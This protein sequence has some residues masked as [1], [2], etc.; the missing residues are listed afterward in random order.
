MN[1]SPVS[2][3]ATPSWREQL[4]ASAFFALSGLAIAP[5]FW[6]GNPCGHDMST[7]FWRVIMFNMNIEDGYPFLQWG[8]HFLRGYGYPIFPFYAPLF[9]WLIAALHAAGFDYNAALRMAAWLALFLC[10]WG[11]YN[12][13]RRY[14]NTSL[15][16]AVAGLAYMFAP[17]IIYDGVERGALPELIALGLLPWVLSRVDIAWERQ[18]PRE[19]IKATAAF[20]LLMLTHNIIPLIGF[21]LIGALWLGR[22]QRVRVTRWWHEAQTG[23]AIIL[24]TLLVSAFFWLPAYLE[25]DYTQQARGLDSP[26][27]D[28]PVWYQH[29]LPTDELVAWPSD[30]ADVRLAN[31]PQ[32]RTLGIAQ[33]IIAG[34][35]LL[36][37][38]WRKEKRGT[39]LIWLLITAGALY[40]SNAS[41]SWLWELLPLPTFVQLPTRLLGIASLGLAILVGRFADELQLLPARAAYPFTAVLALAVCVSGW[42]W[43]TRPYCAFPDNPDVLTLATAA[44]WEG[45]NFY[46]WGGANGAE[47]LPRWADALPD[48]NGL[49]PQYKAGGPVNRLLLTESSTLINWQHQANGDSYQL[50]LSEPLTATYQSFYMPGWVAQINGEEVPI[51]PSDTYGLITVPLPAGTVDLEI[52]FGATPLRQA[53]VLVSLVALGG[54][55]WFGRRSNQTETYPFDL[56]QQAPIFTAVVGLILLTRVAVA[57]TNNPIEMNRFQ[58]GQLTHVDIAHQIVFSN[59]MINLGVSGDLTAA[60]DETL[61]ITQYWTPVGGIGVQYDFDMRIADDAGRQWNLPTQKPVF[62]IDIPGVNGWREGDYVRDP[63]LLD[64]LPGTPPGRYWLETT[65]FRRDVTF[66]LTAENAPTAADP[67]WARLGQIEI[68]PPQTQPDLT[69]DKAD[70]QTIHQQTLT[71]QP[72]LLLYGASL[73]SFPPVKPYDEVIIELLWQGQATF[74]AP[75]TAVLELLDEMGQPIA[76]DIL[77]VGGRYPTDQWPADAVVRQQTAWPLPRELES[78]RYTLQLEGIE[79]GMVEVVAPDRQFTRPDID[80]TAEATFGFAQLDGY[81]LSEL[82]DEAPLTLTLLW[83]ALEPTDINYRVFVHLRDAAGQIVAQSDGEPAQWARPTRGWLTDEYIV[84][85]HSLTLPPDLA[86]GEYQINVGLYNPATMARLGESTLTTIQ[87][88]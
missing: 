62:H 68:L 59:Q 23:V 9:N 26:F 87:K 17:Y 80:Q 88:P 81:T 3:K 31:P 2:S 69:P 13:G 72:N 64:L 28:W 42:P 74:E 56:R 61:A 39:F 15:P 7:H 66:A 25:L 40:L 67:A 18:T 52:H 51:T 70:V 71:A 54:L 73:I 79:L 30:P 44:S 48:P 86:A 47:T 65:A 37:L 41:A 12:L 19:F 29:F 50:Q 63:Y 53:M 46:Q 85:E 76:T 24:A 84:D 10:G 36:T 8:Q 82:T 32:V 33:V 27:A 20:A 14:F 21:L 58:A 6:R 78:G 83:Q 35:G 4:F 57:Y 34:L 1:S 77:T 16:A 55:L 43:L 60:A 75:Q 45:D 11:M 5:T 38:L 49:I 22:F